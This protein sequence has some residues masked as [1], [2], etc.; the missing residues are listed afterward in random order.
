[1]DSLLVDS[2]LHIVFGSRP[3]GK[4]IH[5]WYGLVVLL[6]MLMTLQQPRFHAAA[7]QYVNLWRTMLSMPSRDVHLTFSMKCTLHTFYTLVLLH[8]GDVSVDML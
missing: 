5:Y 1:M 6:V 2:L 3:R 4:S 7:C 8:F